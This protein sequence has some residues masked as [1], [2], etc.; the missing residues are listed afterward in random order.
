[1]ADKDAPF[2]GL[3]SDSLSR[4]R[5]MIPDEKPVADSAA[6]LVPSPPELDDSLADFTELPAYKELQVFEAVSEQMGI[7]NPY[8]TCHQSIA[9]Q[10]TI[11]DGQEFLNYSTYDYLGL[12]GH[13]KVKEAAKA[14]MDAFGTSAGASRLLA[15]ERPMHREFEDNLA[16][17]YNA[18]AAL[19]FVSGHATNVST[20]AT[21]LSAG[22][23]IFYDALVHDSILQGAR[24]SGAQRY[25]YTHNDCD[26]LERLLQKHR[27]KHRRALIATEGLFSMDGSIAKLPR[28]IELKKAFKCFLMVDEA[29]ALGVL[30][31]TGRGS[32]E[33]LGLDPRQ[34][35]I[36]MGTL[37]KSMCGCGGFIA[38][39]KELIKLLRFKAPGFVYSVGLSPVLTAGSNAA[40][41]LM[42]AEPERVSRLRDISAFFMNEAKARGLNT[43][44]AQGHAIIP[45]IVGSSMATCILCQRLYAKKINVMPIIY[46]TVEE[47]L[48]RLR[49]FLSAVHEKELVPQVLDTVV[50]EL[51][52]ARKD[53]EKALGGAR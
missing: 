4:L 35:D 37:S 52:A 10:R 46:P 29:H 15:G 49:F 27:G 53:A 40:L 2:F 38:G 1:M 33:H 23:A 20:V 13:P 34:V 50:Q 44:H 11:I 32:A 25:S 42:L 5:S 39:S 45:I 7:F 41:K 31:A 9:R 51:D 28:I 48:A 17:V 21:V 8:H 47:G 6:A 26:A 19:V 16:G 12:N 36:W 24:L 22:D 30:G 3:D 18:D 14:A 43:G